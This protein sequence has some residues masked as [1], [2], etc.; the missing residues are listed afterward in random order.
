MP[1][2]SEVPESTKTEKARPLPSRAPAPVLS[3]PV[4]RRLR[5]ARL[6]TLAD[7]DRRLARCIVQV[8]AG[9]ISPAQCRAIS[10][11][12]ARMAS[13]KSAQTLE[14]IEARL[15]RLESGR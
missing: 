3:T 8:E 1:S 9:D 15:A 7:I 6:A 14:A 13:V 2:P 5:G 4:R 10:D 11:A 12:L